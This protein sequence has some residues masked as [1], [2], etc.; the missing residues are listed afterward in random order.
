[1]IH[2]PAKIVD[3]K[4]SMDRDRVR[5]CVKH[6]HQGNYL[7][8]LISMDN[9]RNEREW[10]KYYRVLLKQMSEDTGYSPSE[11]HEYAKTDVLS[12]KMG[13]DSTT[14]LDSVLWREYIEHLGD[15]SLEKFDFVI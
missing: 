12:P 6:M 2:F 11:M 13:L 9:D 15:W 10:Q 14:E 7:M 5:S 8:V 4:L 3:G 1:M